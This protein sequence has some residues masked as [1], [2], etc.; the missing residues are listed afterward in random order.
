MHFNLSLLLLLSHSW[1]P[2]GSQRPL[3][4]EYSFLAGIVDATPKPADAS[5]NRQPTALA[6]A[7]RSFLVGITDA[8]PKPVGGDA[9]P[10]EAALS[11]RRRLAQLTLS[12][13]PFVN[14]RTLAPVSGGAGDCTIGG[15]GQ[16]LRGFATLLQRRGKKGSPARNPSF[17]P[18]EVL[19]VSIS[20]CPPVMRA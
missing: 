9:R 20:L 10:S 17:P 8:T 13:Q 14:L 18:H 2:A 12:F 6:L 4:T 15:S 5:A 1:P 11:Q 7:E 19:G 3:P 16:E